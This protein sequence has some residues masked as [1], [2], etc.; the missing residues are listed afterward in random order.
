MKKLLSLPPYLV[1][2]FHRL[3]NYSEDDFFC[4]S[5]PADQKLGSGGGTLWLLH[6]AYRHEQDRNDESRLS[7]GFPAWLAREKRVIVHAGG[8]SRRLAAYAPSSKLLLPTPFY[9]QDGSQPMHRYLLDMQLPLAERILKAAP[10]LMHTLVVSGDV[11]IHYDKPLPQMNN[12]DVICFGIPGSEELLSHHG[13]FYMHHDNPEQLDFMLQKPTVAIQR[14]LNATHSALMDIGLWLL[15]DKAVERINRKTHPKHDGA[16]WNYYDLYSDFGGALGNHPSAPS[17]ELSS[18]K[19]CILALDGGAFYHFGTAAEVISST[20]AL[21]KMLPTATPQDTSVLAQNSCVEAATYEGHKNIWIE[22]SHVGPK[23]QL[24]TDHLITGVPK[25]DWAISLPANVCLDIVPYEERKWVVRLYGIHDRFSGSLH[26]AQTTYLNEPFSQWLQSRQLNLS[27]FTPDTDI[28]Q[29]PIF[30]VCDD[31]ALIP[32]LID[33]ILF[34][35]G[36]CSLYTGAEKLSAAQLTDRANLRRLFQQRNE[37]ALCTHLASLSDQPE[38]WLSQFDLKEMAKVC[39]SQRQRFPTLSANAT[40]TAQSHYS[41]MQAEMARL[42]NNDE[43]A[44]PSEADAFQVLRHTILSD[45]GVEPAEPHCDVHPDQMVCAHSA[46]RI[47]LAG[48]WTDTP[49]FSIY[50]GGNVVNMAINLNDQQPIQVYVKACP[51]LHIKCRSIDLGAEETIETYE[52]VANYNRLRSPFSIPKA[53]LALCG[54]LPDRSTRPFASLRDQLTAFG[55]GFEVS[56]VAAIPAGSGL[57]TSS[58]LSAA[59]LAALSDFCGLHW[60]TDTIGKQTL[61]LEQMLTSGGGWQDQYGGILPGVK[62]LHSE[63]GSRQQIVADPLSD[64]LFTGEHSDCHLLYYTG[65]T[66]TAKDILGEIVRN[67]FLNERETTRILYEMK[68][69]ALRMAAAIQSGQ[70][71]EY[72]RL[73]GKSWELNKRLDKGTCPPTIQALCQMIDD[74]CFGYKLPG[75]GGGG[76]LYMVAKDPTAAQSIRNILQPNPLTPTARFVGL[77]ISEKGLNVTRS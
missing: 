43:A 44:K 36:D 49:P 38:E 54:F 42:A 46:V 21:N 56:L 66:R 65:I 35:K 15:S 32:Q 16:N 1:D 23:W 10:S 26:D 62:L 20:I 41:M 34:G 2:Q 71:E 33:F 18:L 29:T 51:E 9:L 69:H 50:K 25:N 11:F 7:D 60:A 72:G 64:S 59:V 63:A 19:V 57:G 30:P 28:Q 45:S 8:Q 47:D 77:S 55:G 58:V 52:Q 24:H 39:H 31:I 67:M 3:T 74:Y 48:G 6:Q 5:D 68:E 70:F 76:F 61:L 27:M 40:A 4:S 37:L 75:A 13:A 22:N 14:Q 73:V 12:A 53:A 17:E